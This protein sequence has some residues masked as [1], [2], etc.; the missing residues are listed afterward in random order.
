MSILKLRTPEFDAY[1]ARFLARRI[2]YWRPSRRGGVSLCD[3]HGA[4]ILWTSEIP[5]PDGD[6]IDVTFD[7]GHGPTRVNVR[8]WESRKRAT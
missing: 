4:V 8:R 2:C 5:I 3:A 1:C 6:Y 7:V